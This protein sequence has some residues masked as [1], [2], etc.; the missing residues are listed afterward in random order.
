MMNE[1]EMTPREQA[2]YGREVKLISE[3][4]N[5]EIAPLPI[6]IYRRK[7]AHFIGRIRHGMYIE[8]HNK[9]GTTRHTLLH[10][11]THAYLHKRYEGQ[12]YKKPHR[13]EFWDLFKYLYHGGTTVQYYERIKKHEEKVAMCKIEKKKPEHK[14]SRAE[15]LLKKWQTKQKRA[16]TAIKK[17]EKKIKRLRKNEV[18]I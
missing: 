3:K 11:L 1:F 17:L 7:N 14:I 8:L 9:F 6:K 13:Q 16:E 15:V 4:F 18:Q 2:W 5:N 10:E 12:S